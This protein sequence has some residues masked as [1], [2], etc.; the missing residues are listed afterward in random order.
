MKDKTAPVHGHYFIM[1]TGSCWR[2]SVWSLQLSKSEYS[3]R[4]F[5]KFIAVLCGSETCGL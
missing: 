3:I 2:S 1:V 5:H 4:K